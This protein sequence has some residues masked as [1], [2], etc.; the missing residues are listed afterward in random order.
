MANQNT[1]RKKKAE[2]RQKIKEGA[3]KPQNREERRRAA[4]EKEKALLNSLET[5]IEAQLQSDEMFETS[6]SKIQAQSRPK[7]RM[8]FQFFKSRMKAWLRST[9]KQTPPT[10]A[11]RVHTVYNH[12]WNQFNNKQGLYILVAVR[13][14]ELKGQLHNNVTE[15]NAEM[16][17]QRP[18]RYKQYLAWRKERRC[19]VC[20]YSKA[21]NGSA[22]CEKCKA[23]TNVKQLKFK[24]ITFSAFATNPGRWKES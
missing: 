19:E 21:K 6:I 3:I 2:R 1:V 9:L 15:E 12:A 5:Y 11:N 23:E 24:P 7:V 14:D 13:V 10:E 16:A 20:F 22:M 8:N 17:H 18:E 4:E